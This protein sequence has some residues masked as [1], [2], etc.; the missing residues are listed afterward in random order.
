M[1]KNNYQKRPKSGR[2]NNNMPSSAIP[3]TEKTEE[4][5]VET[6][7]YKNKKNNQEYSETKITESDE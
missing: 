2:Q 5:L 1:K 6:I 7:T 4:T 3:T